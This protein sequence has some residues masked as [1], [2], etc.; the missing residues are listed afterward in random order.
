MIKGKVENT[1]KDD[2]SNLPRKISILRLDTDWY[3]STKVELEVLYPR[4]EKNGILIIDDYGGW[5]GS[6][7][8]VDEFFKNKITT[9]FRIDREARFI[10]KN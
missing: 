4:L 10:I 2:H 1:L 9:M 5:L 7:K 6:K 8:A 3:E